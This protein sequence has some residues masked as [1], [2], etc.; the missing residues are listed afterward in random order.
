MSNNKTYHS[1]EELAADLQFIQWIKEGRPAHTGT[2]YDNLA[3]QENIEWIEPAAVLVEGLY[4]EEMV[5]SQT[6]VEHLWNRIDQDTHQVEAKVRSLPT[7]L[8]KI[9]A[10]VVILIVAGWYFLN[11]Q[12]DLTEVQTQYAEVN[13]IHLP[14]GSQVQLNADSKILYDAED[15]NGHRQIHLEGEA[16]FKVAKRERF[17]VE[18]AKGKVEVLGTSFNVFS[19]GEAFTVICHSGKVRVSVEDQKVILQAGE[20][21]NLK[22][23]QLQ[24]E[25]VQVDPQKTWMNGYFL[26]ENVRLDRVLAE[27][28]RQFQVE[29]ETVDIDTGR[30]Y[31]GFFIRNNLSEALQSVCWPLRLN[32]DINGNKVKISDG[33]K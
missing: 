26:Y 33:T 9:A 5:I 19:R 23:N 1:V 11:V 2:W 20:K 30:L 27:I 25:E 10:S 24:E 22:G 28:E 15:W 31:S 6:Q 12:N 18:T 21:A 4:F 29:I 7:Q 32:F 8:L 3:A 14:D 13:D 16:F 17:T